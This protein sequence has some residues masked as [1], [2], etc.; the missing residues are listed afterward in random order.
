M[1]FEAA[2][3]YLNRLGI[4]A[5]KG[6]KPSLHR[7]EV[8]CEALDH[9]ERA[10]PALHVTGTNGKTSTARIAASVLA[11]TGLKV[12]IYTSPHLES[13]RERIA[14]AEEPIPEEEF[15]AT[16]DHL[17][18]FVEETERRLEEPLSY[19]EILTGAFFLWAAEAGIDASVVEV[20]L[21]G[22]WDATNVVQATV[23]VVTNIGIDH[24]ALLGSERTDIAR[25]KAGIIKS[26]SAVVSAERSPALAE[27]VRLQA[28]AVGA[29]TTSFVD[30]DWRVLE[31][32]TAIGGRYLTVE[33]NA[34][35]YEGLFLPLHGS[36]QG[37]NAGTA[38]EAVARFLPAN[39]LDDEVVQEGL[40]STIS[41]GRLEAFRR[42]EHA[43]V[44]LD[45]AHNPDG[46]SALVK[47]LVE[48][49]AFGRIH[50]VV[51]ISSDKDHR[52]MLVEIARVATT[53]VVTEPQGV[54]AAPA[55]TLKDEAAATGVQTIAV[56][57]PD[58]ALTA[59]LDRADPEDI[60]CVTGSHYLVGEVRGRLTAW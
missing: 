59:A 49:F 37:V 40:R 58:A 26:D 12:G 56:Q 13:V 31:N 24:Q 48:D 4:D 5:M 11:A 2:E 47:A 22:R 19:F 18:P 14:L 38:L 15:A 60:V 3:A 51:G 27:I 20:G 36:H 44:V 17:V 32:T 33:T 16:L 9:P 6:L 46:V 53:V 34:R 43:T 50:F 52:G 30:R 21:G 23:A 42:P 7:I 55:A 41:P 35:L 1:D 57:N 28:D 39:P 25:E 45:V 8:L 29:A 54:R 10:V